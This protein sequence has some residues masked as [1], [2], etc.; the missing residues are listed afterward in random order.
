M[1]ESVPGFDC[2]W[3]AYNV[4]CRKLLYFMVRKSGA[5]LRAGLAPAPLMMFVKAEEKE[6]KFV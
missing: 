4:L 2:A 6:R 5:Y 1:P 3:I